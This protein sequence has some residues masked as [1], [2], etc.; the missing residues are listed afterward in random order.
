MLGC[1]EIP[2]AT[3]G[4]CQQESCHQIQPSTVDKNYK[5]KKKR[6]ENLIYCYDLGFGWFECVP[7]SAGCLDLGVVR[8]E[9]N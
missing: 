5:F 9:L 2:C 7:Q 4:L 1:F 6:K 3:S 8:C